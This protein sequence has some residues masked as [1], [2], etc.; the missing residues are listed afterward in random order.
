M[1]QIISNT[2]ITSSNDLIKTQEGKP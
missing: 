2:S 1:G